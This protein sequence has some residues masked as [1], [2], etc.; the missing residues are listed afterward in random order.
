MEDAGAERQPLL[1]EAHSKT[2]R[3]YESIEQVAVR[4]DWADRPGSTSHPGEGRESDSEDEPPKT[5]N[6]DESA[7]T[8]YVCLGYIFSIIAGLCF[9]SCNIGI[10]FAGLHIAVS[11]WQM[12][13]V[14]CLGQSLGMVPLVW[15]SRS[16]IQAL[17][18]TPILLQ[19]LHPRLA[20]LLHPVEDHS[21]GRGGRPHA[22]LHIRGC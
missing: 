19:V 22:P 11:S 20:R 8:S 17:L 3:Q 1:G 10:K 7:P 15:W 9:T 6:I 5:I 13:F 18:L 4:L 2:L 14:R 16:V 21:P 12:L